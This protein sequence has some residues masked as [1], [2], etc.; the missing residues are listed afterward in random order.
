MATYRI[1]TLPPLEPKSITFTVSNELLAGILSVL[2]LENY[3]ITN[4]NT[5]TDLTAEDVNAIL[6]PYILG[7]FYDLDK[8][9]LTYAE[10]ENYE[11]WTEF[12]IDNGLDIPTKRYSVLIPDI[13]SISEDWTDY[14]YSNIPSVYTFDT[15]D[16]IRGVITTNQWRNY[17]PYETIFLLH[18]GNTPLEFDINDQP[19]DGY[20]WKNNGTNNT[21]ALPTRQSVTIKM[22]PEFY[23]HWSRKGGIENFMDEN[24]L[25][26]YPAKTLIIINSPGGDPLYLVMS[27]GPG[28]GLHYERYPELPTPLYQEAVTNSWSMK[29]V[30][31]IYNLPFTPR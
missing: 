19:T 17:D 4:L 5:N 29:D 16:F 10:A 22:S 27:K 3:R 24:N 23:I 25:S 12:L 31:K 6:E 20:A 28:V 21:T 18:E 9:W 15:P 7:D 8:S 26:S 1:Q 30:Q 2:A 13:L 11:P 14:E